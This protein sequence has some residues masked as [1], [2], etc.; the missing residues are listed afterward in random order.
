MVYGKDARTLILPYC[1]AGEEVTQGSE[2]IVAKEG[3]PR[4]DTGTNNFQVKSKKISAKLLLGEYTFS[5]QKKR[6]FSKRV[7]VKSF[8]KNEHT[9]PYRFQSSKLENLPL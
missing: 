5:W 3:E 8:A 1:V 9:S 7:K 4:S 6:K 2:E